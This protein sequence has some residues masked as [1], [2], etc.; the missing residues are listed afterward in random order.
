MSSVGG[1]LFGS[2]GM[3][4]AYTIISKHRISAMAESTET[5]EVVTEGVEVVIDELVQEFEDLE[6]KIVEDSTV[7]VQGYINILAN[8]RTDEDAVKIKEK[9]IYGYVMLVIS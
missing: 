5:M 1:L 6:D 3:V 2:L 4:R 8:P 9:C 7:A